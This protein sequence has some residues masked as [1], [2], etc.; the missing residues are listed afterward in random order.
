MSGSSMSIHPEG[1]GNRMTGTR[2]GLSTASSLG[3][4]GV[5]LAVLAVLGLTAAPALAA[6][7]HQFTGSFGSPGSG[8]GQLGEPAGIAVNE[9]T[10]DIYY[11]DKTND[12]VEIFNSTGSKFEGEFNGSGLGLGTLGSG[13][14]LNEGK[15]AGSGGL[16]EEV[17][18]GKF[19]KPVGIAIDN[20]PS[21]PS[22]GDVYVAD[23]EGNI[24]VIKQHPG[25]TPEEEKMASEEARTVV[26]KFSASGEYIGQI[27]RNVTGEQYSEN[28]FSEV[29][30][31][32]VD[33][34]GE[35]WVLERNYGGAVED[36][37]NYA[38][39]VVN[40]RIASR[41]SFG[42]LAGLLAGSTVTGGFFAVDSEDNFYLSHD[43]RTV[44]E[45][46]ATEE[47]VVEFN[48]NGQFLSGTVE[49][50]S[51]IEE[52]PVDGEDPTGLAVELSSNDVYVGHS[53]NVHRVD[54][55]GRSLESLSVPGGH[56]SS[57]AVDTAT[58]TVYA[59][60]SVAGVVDI[61]GP[62]AAAAPTVSAGSES[63]EEVTATSVSFS[64]EVNPRS[65]AGEE[66]TSYSFEYGPCG[67]PTTCSSSPY[68]D[69]VPAPT[70]V[71]AANYEPDV[72]GAH[73][74][75]LLAHTA[76]HMRLV[77]H[78]SHPGVAEGEELTFTTQAA[79]AFSFPDGR[80]WEMVS[81]PDKYGALIR[82]QK[83]V[84]EA[85]VNGDA[86]T[87][88][89]NAPIEAQ[90]PGNYQSAV[91]ALA[92]RTPGGWQSLDINGPHDSAPGA[93]GDDEYPFFSTDL[94]LSVLQPF[95]AFVPSLSS[96]ASEQTPFL[97]TDFS[98]GNPAHLCT[99]SC[100]SPL[101][102]GAPGVEN[103]PFGTV[104][105]KGQAGGECVIGTCGPEFVGASPDV[106][107]IVLQYRWA[108]L[109]EGAPLESL[110]EWTGGRL[111]VIS[112]LP[113]ESLATGG[114]LGGINRGGSPGATHVVRNAVSADGSRVVWSYGS[115]LYLRDTTSEKTVQLDEVQ[116]GSGQGSSEPGFQTAS[117]DG[118]RIFFTDKQELTKDASGSADLYE[119]EIVEEAGHLGCRLSD[120]TGGGGES[121]GVMEPILGAS[122]DGS[123]VYFVAS[124][125]LTGG[126]ANDRGEVAV[127]GQHNLYVHHEGV[128]TLVAVLSSEDTTDWSQD[129]HRLTARVSPDGHWLSFM[130]QRSLTG[131]DNRDVLSGKHDGEVFLYHADGNGEGRLVCASC[132][133]TGGRPQGILTKE[134]QGGGFG[135]G[136]FEE[137]QN[138]AAFL[139]GWTSPFYQSRYLS[140]SGRLFFNSYDALAPQDTNGAEDVYQF[141]P[142][143]VGGCTA[144]STTFVVASGGC[145]GLVSSG[146]SKDDS[147]FVDASE[148]GSDVFFLT[149]AQLSPLD[150]DTVL[151]IYDAHECGAGEDCSPPAAT[152][153]PACEGDACQ[154]PVAA[155]EDP[156]P[157]SLT[158]Q[159]P[160]NPTAVT[161][162][163]KPKSKAKPVKCKKGS[164][165]QRG[166][167]VKKRKKTKAKRSRLSTRR[168]K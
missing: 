96:E 117:S 97:R 26:D 124:G 115:H 153:V 63:I 74:Q 146:T 143:G 87:Y 150:T 12:R 120:L 127:A 144:T 128:T 123:Y 88:W 47:R 149:K 132:N 141:E 158:Y 164:I 1:K 154:S 25:E 94:S 33:S 79:G 131:F 67:T 24:P 4:R 15:A 45:G 10:G 84:T 147:V 11:L 30:G 70:G 104:F 3:G 13:Q 111:S 32:A 92:D 68:V 102:T 44:V 136:P 157:G 105:G 109:V 23:D 49:G 61:F 22:Y 77:A 20:D 142:S 7:G 8:P 151:D 73:P 98:S 6:R 53:S 166:K 106:S 160:G 21:S 76:Y 2:R 161:L 134:V 100:Y 99:S 139:P 83:N 137:T 118:S 108:P 129:L 60:D 80:N 41:A 59:A 85:S 54:A 159:G 69:S 46:P 72:V 5:V 9:A 138:I 75:D 155:P 81:P 112:V 145:V 56:G 86:I 167:C 43:I 16:P 18:T 165:R 55:S 31:V 113:N 114:I 51:V 14:L 152:P 148:S 162:N 38:N 156:T 17:A 119:C 52:R 66:A 103:V 58:S 28:G 42:G 126:Q 93:L 122:E 168:G 163:A 110:Y 78:N 29:F 36:T 40:I 35:L 65:N 37:V 91:Q 107:H 71:L 39:G 62:A 64:A 130:S 19:G 57:V 135:P 89:A 133:P 121:T 116:G 95:G 82:A 140:N 50:K 90:P 101:V 34:H 48:A 125:V 27:S